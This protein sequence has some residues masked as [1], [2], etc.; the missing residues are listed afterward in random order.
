[1][2]TTR[3]L[4]GVMFTVCL[5]LIP[6]EIKADLVVAGGTG[7]VNGFPFG[8]NGFS[9]S[10]EYQQIYSSTIF[11]GPVA[12]TQI[13]FATVNQ[14]IYTDNLALSLSTTSKTVNGMSTTYSDNIGPDQATKFSGI[15]VINAAGTKSCDL[16]FTFST[17][18]NFD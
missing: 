3:S 10:G 5:L 16:I 11:G 7:N 18:F 12:I 15:K 8:N 17:P 13:A 14:Q 2:K 6:A 9:Y 1:M 4:L